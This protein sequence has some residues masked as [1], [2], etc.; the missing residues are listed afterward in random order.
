MCPTPFSW[1]CQILKESKFGSMDNTKI[2]II[3]NII[4]QF[5]FRFKKYGIFSAP[6]LQ[7]PPAFM[8]PGAHTELL[9]KKSWRQ[10][11]LYFCRFT[12]K[13]W[14][15]FSPQKIIFSVKIQY[16]S[17]DIWCTQSTWGGA[18]A[19]WPQGGLEGGLGRREEGPRQT[20]VSQWRDNKTTI[21]QYKY[22]CKYKH[23][24]KTKIQK[25]IHTCIRCYKL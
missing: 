18:P 7:P 23:K 25:K 15:Y 24:Y 2:L 13:L 14:S 10:K 1:Q 8:A 20:T 4:F 21:Q 9:R 17:P 5:S 19:W 11:N 3:N 12:C 6:T 16:F 22:K